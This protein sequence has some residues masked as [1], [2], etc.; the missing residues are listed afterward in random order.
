ERRIGGV[1]LDV[2]DPEPLP[3]DDPLWRFDNAIITPHYSGGRP[4]YVA[5]VAEIFLGNLER[6]LAGRPLVNV[7]DKDAGY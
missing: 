7:V 6:Y 4:D 3:S 5:Q 1:G 2:T